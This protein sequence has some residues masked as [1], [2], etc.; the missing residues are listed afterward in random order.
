MIELKS[1]LADN[2]LKEVHMKDPRVVA[3]NLQQQ[4]ILPEDENL[5]LAPSELAMFVFALC[6]TFEG[7]TTRQI[8]IL[9]HTLCILEPAGLSIDNL[10][11]VQ[12]SYNR[13]AFVYN[14]GSVYYAG[15][16]HGEACF[17][18]LPGQWWEKFYHFVNKY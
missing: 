10:K 5:P 2:C 12:I 4:G 3:F 9:K 14:D 1:L 6:T 15:D 17:K 16:D 18:V 11:E 7:D 8:G 13:V